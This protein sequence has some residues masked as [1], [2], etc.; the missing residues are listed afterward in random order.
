M[1]KICARKKP[2]FS[3]FSNFNARVKWIPSKNH[4]K[5]VFHFLYAFVLRSQ[6]L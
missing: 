4:E 1:D 6:D 5:F 2:H 3:I